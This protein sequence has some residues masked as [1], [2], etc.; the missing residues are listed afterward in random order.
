MST[1]FYDEHDTGPEWGTPEWV[2]EPLE[3]AI[4]GFNLDPASGAEPRPYAE[5]RWTGDEIDGLARDWFGRVWLNPP[6]GRSHNPRWAEKVR[7]QVVARR[8]RSVT[9]LVPAST[10]TDWWQD[11]YAHADAVTFLDTRLS[12]VG[13]GDTSASFAS[14]I[15]SF[16][17]FPEAYWSALDELGTTFREGNEPGGSEQ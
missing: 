11:S 2:V 17:S 4:G 15:C 7:E 6:Y 10:S 13:S 5:E 16:G 3:D 12:F 14:C 8:P 1:E 9:A